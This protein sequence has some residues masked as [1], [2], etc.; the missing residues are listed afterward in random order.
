M[1]KKELYK[2]IYDKRKLLIV[3]VFVF[4]IC[5]DAWL[6]FR[7]SF[8]YEA[9]RH[10]ELEYDLSLV[11]ENSRQPFAAAFLSS[12]SRGHIPQKLIIWLLPL[13]FLMITSDSYIQEKRT[14]YIS[15]M[16]V[17]MKKKDI[18]IKQCLSSFLISFS[19]SSLSLI[20]NLIICLILFQNGERPL[21]VMDHIISIYS[22]QYPYLTYFIYIIVFSLF[23]GLLAASSHALSYLIP[24]HI[25][26]YIIIFGIWF[27]Q[28]GS[29]NSIA[30]VLQPYIEFGLER[31]IPSVIFFLM[32]CFVPIILG[33]IKMVKYDDL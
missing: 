29:Y 26:L 24:L 5:F 21:M 14:N 20:L 13:Y 28:I 7:D 3:F 12:A 23:C 4:F 9:M 22:S 17:R 6:A 11:Y 1:I 15:I 25:P 10:P 33:Y 31:I 19:I 30:F 2:L 32:T 18:F 8:L 27:Y 16:K